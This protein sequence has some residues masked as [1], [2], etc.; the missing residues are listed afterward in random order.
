MLRTINVIN[1]NL[2]F[3]LY[4]V[5]PDND[6]TSKIVVYVYIK[7][8][9]LFEKCSKIRSFAYKIAEMI[10]IVKDNNK[11]TV[12]ISR[13]RKRIVLRI[14]LWPCMLYKTIV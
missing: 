11:K 9:S 6:I 10:V 13:K 1:F 12:M 5:N 3:D 4:A 8:R 7:I 2:F 14:V